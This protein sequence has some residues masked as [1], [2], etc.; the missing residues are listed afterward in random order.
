M[1]LTDLLRTLGFHVWSSSSLI[2]TTAT[3]SLHLPPR[4]VADFDGAQ[5]AV[6]VKPNMIAVGLGEAFAIY[7]PPSPAHAG[8]VMLET[9]RHIQSVSH[10]I[11][12]Y[13]PEFVVHH[14]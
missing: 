6:W 12:D 9:W 7:A 8:N 1:D 4:V 3:Q 11:S 5:F 14:L 10:A 13:G 2:P